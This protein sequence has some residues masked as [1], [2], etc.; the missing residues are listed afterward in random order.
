MRL[1]KITASVIC[2]A[3][4][5]LGSCL[6]CN[7]IQAEESAT[8]SD[9]TFLDK[10][11]TDEPS[12]INDEFEKNDYLLDDYIRLYPK[13]EYSSYDPRNPYYGSEPGYVGTEN[14]LVNTV[15]KIKTVKNDYSKIEVGYDN[16]ENRIYKD[17]GIYKIVFKYD[18]IGNIFETET[19]YYNNSTSYLKKY[20]YN[21]NGDIT[22]I[23]SEKYDSGVLTDTDTSK[24]EYEYDNKNKKTKI[25]QK[26]SLDT[27][28]HI[29][30]YD[31]K[32]NVIEIDIDG[33]LFDSEYKYKFDK[34]GNIISGSEEGISFECEY[35]NGKLVKLT[36]DSLTQTYEYDIRGNL[37]KRT[38]KSTNSTSTTEYIY[39]N[40]YD[41]DGDIIEANWI[42]RT[43]KDGV[44]I[45]YSD[46]HTCTYEYYDNPS[47]GTL[48]TTGIYCASNYPSIQAGINIQK[49]NPSD[50]VEYKWVGCNN[51]NPK[52][53][54]EV[55]PWTKNNNWMNW[56]PKES[57]GYVFVCYAR[58]VGQ[59]ET[60]IQYAFGTEYHKQ[61]KGICQ[62]PYTG[63]GGGYLIGIESYDNPN[64][65]YQYEMLILDCNLYM[66]GKD[67]W[68]YTTG[69]CGADGNCLWTV[70][71]PVY[72]YY[73]TL[74]RIYDSSTGEL[75]D[76][77][78][79]GF[80]NVN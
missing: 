45:G 37:T 32:G 27:Y 56:T 68:V 34:D 57:G 73:W 16:R 2:G 1:R 19:S 11:E 46:E 65:K 72:G 51:N 23:V 9:A 75:V 60:E 10:A 38:E 54:F 44:V 71:Q 58:I 48:S 15:K 25:I 49:S 80:E 24:F 78:C 69:R 39:T 8:D 43:F 42:S 53:W 79:Y 28:T 77:A 3:M 55:S 4:L 14:C 41:S 31:A 20:Q 76:E 17:N 70:W 12:E 13:F 50:V 47:T 52:K 7:I 40:K 21:D 61:I 33:T 6:S 74:F 62:M 22:S 59:P 30:T 18:N 5:V 36:T 63:E 66:Q 29:Y 35:S 67:A 64:H 26:D